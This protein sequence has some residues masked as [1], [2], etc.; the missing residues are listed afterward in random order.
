M[1]DLHVGIFGP[2][3]SGKT[4]LAKHLSRSYW[5]DSNPGIKSLC[6]DPNLEKWGEQAWIT[7]DPVAFEKMA[8]E[9]ERGCAVFVD[10]SSETIDRDKAKTKFFTRIRHCGHKLHVIGHDGSSLLPVQRQ[11]LHTLFLFKQPKS[12][13]KVWAEL[14]GNEKILESC[15]LKQH[16]FLWCR[17]YEG[18]AERR[19]LKL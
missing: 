17:F 6:L 13:A 7:S 4:T 11:Q 14:Y 19:T 5:Y 2:G 9:T 8:F 3:L 12:A 18:T 15:T 16:E 1:S 10:E